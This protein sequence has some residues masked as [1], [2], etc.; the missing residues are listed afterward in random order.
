M[1]TTQ[2]PTQKLKTAPKW[3]PT[4]TATVHAT[5]PLNYP[6]MNDLRSEMMFIVETG[7][8]VESLVSFDHT[9]VILSLSELSIK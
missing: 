4:F 5:F 7:M 6:S 2:N 1:N 8:N 3:R 9:A